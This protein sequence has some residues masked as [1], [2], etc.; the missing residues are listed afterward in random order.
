MEPAC[1]LHPDPPPCRKWHGGGD[2]EVAVRLVQRGACESAPFR[3]S[4]PPLVPGSPPLRH[5][6]GAEEGQGGGAMGHASVLERLF[7]RVP[8]PHNITPRPSGGS[9]RLRD[10]VLTD[11]CSPP[12][13]HPH[14][15]ACR[16][17]RSGRSPGLGII[18]T[19][20]LP[21]QHPLDSGR[22]AAFVPPHSCGAA[23][24]SHP[25][26]SWPS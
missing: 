19:P 4:A 18:L 23:G 12:E 10:R 11:P 24:A 17:I 6:C 14:A 25:L 13:Q 16:L 15:R 26:P 7:C 2:L 3:D 20:H 21:V 5:H 1:G 22:I 9:R 8:S